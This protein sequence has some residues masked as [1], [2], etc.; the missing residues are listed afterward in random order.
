MT[1]K[2]RYLLYLLAATLMLTACSGVEEGDALD[3]S[4][5]AESQAVAFNAYVNRGITRGGKPGVVTNDALKTGTHASYGFGVMAYY[6]E[7]RRYNQ[8]AL[9][10]FMYNQQVTWQTAS[11]PASWTYTPV[12]YWPNE[13]GSNGS[14]KTDYLSFFAYAPYIEVDPATGCDTGS[15]KTGI[16]SLSRPTDNGDPFVRY[17]VS[18]KPAEAVD[19]CWATPHIDQTKPDVSTTVNFSFHHA[20]ASLNVQIDADVDVTSHATDDTKDD[21]T[22]IWVRSI[23]FRGFAERGQLNLNNASVT[24]HWNNLDCDCDLSSDPITIYDGRRDDREG[25]SASLNELRT[26]LNPAIVQSGRYTVT[27]G[28]DPGDPETLTSTTTGVTNTTINLFDPT[29]VSGDDDALRTAPIYVI[30]TNEDLYVTIEYDV[31]TYDPKL[32]TNRLND[33]QTP[34]SCIKN[35]LSATVKD[36]SGAPITMTAGKKYTITL[37][38]GMTS[39]K[40]DATVKDWGAGDTAPVNIPE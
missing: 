28:V 29:G 22:R 19:L 16:M 38:L 11:L 21:Y 3:N 33:G 23:T 26:G 7:S 8:M 15:D 1:C 31:E 30:P 27:P 4:Q 36:G 17:S 25:A 14:S 40:A 35:T 9:P 18:L 10:N 13:T 5:M 37:H 2:N 34:G 12:K 20:L 39:V 6:T 32:A 24:P